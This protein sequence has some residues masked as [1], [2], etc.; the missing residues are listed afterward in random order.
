MDW[1]PRRV[2]TGHDEKGTSVIVS[3]GAPTVV[4]EIAQGHA[5]MAEIWSTNATP[6]PLAP[7]EPE[8]IVTPLV[9]PPQANG[10]VIRYVEFD[11]G[12]TSPMH[13]TE[14]LD[15]GIVLRGEMHMILDD[16]EV[17]LRPGD[18]AIQR[19]T[20][21]AWAN[22][23]TEPVLMI[24]VLVDASFTQDLRDLL[25]AKVHDLFVEPAAE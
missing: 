22:R 3:D 6:A 2:V 10:H 9:V 12:W 16:T 4:E 15:Y 21:H 7:D 25:G 14:S 18:V 11:P 20:D 1:P 5:R 24:F 23:G 13:R 8:P 19:G 17:V